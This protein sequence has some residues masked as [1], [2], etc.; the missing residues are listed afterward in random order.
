MSGSKIKRK[1]RDAIIQ[2]L[3]AGVTPRRGQ[4]HLQV[5]RGDELKALIGDMENVGAGGSTIRFIIGEY[6]SGKTFFLNLV[7]TI[8]MEKKMVAAHADLSPDRRL[9]ATGGQARSLY[10]E[11]MFNLSTR[12]KPD[13][14][15]LGAIIERF[16]SSALAE[17]REQDTSADAVIRNRLASLQEMVGGYDFAE[18]V[19]A[20]WRGHD[21]GDELL[22]TNA[23]RWFRGEFSTKTDARKALG[24]RTI[25]DDANFYDTLKLLSRFFVMAGYGGLLLCLDE[26]VNLYKLS[27]SKARKT[28]YEQILRILNDC[29][30]GNVEGF[31][32]LFGGTPEFLMDP[33]KGLYSYEALQ[34]RLAQNR[35]AS[36]DLKDYS[37]PVISL[38]SLMP[39]DIFVLL[40]K[41]RG[42]YVLNGQEMELIPD[43]GI[44][45][46]LSHC[47]EK[48]GDAYFRTPRNTIVS[49]VNLLAILEQNRDT[50][51]QD[52]IGQVNIN[53]ERPSIFENE[54]AFDE[55]DD[56]ATIQ[57]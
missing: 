42:V 51:W 13:G 39:E 3:R 34:T 4:R 23:M 32:I 10:R 36:D 11:I 35:F 49:F 18:V 25:V 15:A 9:H 47:K 22:K 24:V 8:A 43:E 27:N 53:V 56:L 37:G 41:I 50:S 26:M 2:S 14:G 16:I 7:R 54:E 33:R 57:L 40:Q 44:T 12:T 17:A 29:L 45:A 38:G 21:Q 20:Y 55:D 30:Q 52:L 5:G 31:G 46:F 28:N 19:A 48:I 6:G 1:D